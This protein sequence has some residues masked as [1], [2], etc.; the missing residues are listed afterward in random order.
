M[1]K[2]EDGK[3]IRPKP[4]EFDLD[5][6][7]TPIEG[8]KMNYF[9]DRYDWTLIRT[10]YINDRTVT[11][12]TLS[13]KY[14]CAY[15]TIRERCAKEQWVMDRNRVHNEFVKIATTE[16]LRRQARAAITFN[17]SCLD[18]AAK[19]VTLA[20]QRI[21]EAIENGEMIEANELGH[22]A[23]AAKQAQE[24]GRLALGLPTNSSEITGKD[25][26]PLLE[27]SRTADDINAELLLLLG[28]DAFNAMKGIK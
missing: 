15:V 25:G 21:D 6:A 2:D 1:T 14:G 17:S 5:S 10:E 4:I 7:L 23:R 3:Y 20:N 26:K 13:E 28:E 11:L 19:I 8:K 18:V 24:T 27:E 16:N 9:E 22:L 12:K